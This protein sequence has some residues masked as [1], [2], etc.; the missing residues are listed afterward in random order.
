MKRIFNKLHIFINIQIKLA[1]SKAFLCGVSH[2]GTPL[3]TA[4]P[5]TVS[6]L[7]CGV[8]VRSLLIFIFLLLVI[9]CTETE[10]IG[11]SEARTAVLK[12]ALTKK[13]EAQ[14][15]DAAYAG[16][17]T[18]ILIRNITGDRILFE[19]DIDSPYITASVFKIVASG[20]ALSKFGPEYKFETIIGSD[21]KIQE[22][23]IKGNLYIQGRGDAS[24]S[25]L[26]LNNISDQLAS[27]GLKSVEGDLVYDTSWFDDEENRFGNN[28]RNL[29]APPS[30]LT[31]NYGWIDVS[32]LNGNP[33]Q[34]KLVPE[35]SYAKMIYNVA[36][37]KSD[38]WGRPNMTFLKRS[39]GDEYS[40]HGTIASKDRQYHYLWLGVSRPGLFAATRFKENLEKNGVIIRG[41]I[42]KGTRPAHSLVLITHVSK[43][44]KAIVATMNQESNNVIA[45]MI[46][47]S[48]AASFDSL[49]GTREKGL[50]V[51]K[52]YF[53]EKLGFQKGSFSIG[54]SSGL[55]VSNRLSPMQVCKILEHYYSKKNIRDAFIPTLAW[56]GHHPH[57]M[58]P[59][60]PDD[61][62]VYVK[63]GTLSVQGVNTVA[64]YIFC[65]K[66]KDIFSFAI[67]ANRLKPGPMTYSGTLTNPL[68]SMV[69]SALE[70][71]NP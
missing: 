30:A 12:E 29:Y 18:G 43:P 61:I 6:V 50:N 51:I 15:K 60:P 38:T 41:K 56:Q 4:S 9:S 62:R 66:T 25:D 14:L 28:A 39:W 45:E 24:L 31:V 8:E 46:N 63:T 69:I 40:I 20:I 55:S 2:K 11:I 13:I 17:K 16:V 68:L 26:D 54:D 48:L 22:G 27:A 3:K 49:P 52:K 37:S 33:I 34:M 65:D 64:G 10:K 47:K 21:N 35:T 42:V 57:A 5:K 7:R 71:S 1:L 36:W 44:L 23:F 53:E 67:M 59:V 70:E 58:N 19:K 32:V